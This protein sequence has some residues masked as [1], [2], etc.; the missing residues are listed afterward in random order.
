MFESGGHVYSCFARDQ[1]I[2]IFED[3]KEL[4]RFDYGLKEDINRLVPLQ[5]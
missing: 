3:Y 1:N 5:F 2:I 4:V